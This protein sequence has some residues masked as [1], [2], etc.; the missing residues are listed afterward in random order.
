MSVSCS[1]GSSDTCCS[2]LCLLVRRKCHCGLALDH[3]C[4]LCPKILVDFAHRGNQT[5]TQFHHVSWLFLGCVFDGLAHHPTAIV[6]KDVAVMHVLAPAKIQAI[7]CRVL[8]RYSFKISP[9]LVRHDSEGDTGTNCGC[10]KLKKFCVQVVVHDE[11]VSLRNGHDVFQ[12]FIKCPVITCVIR[13]AH[14]R[15]RK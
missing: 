12:V 6:Q 14:C 4:G 5:Y 2:C 15:L 7:T 9:N 8:L 13:P 10:V 3:N 11:D 1:G